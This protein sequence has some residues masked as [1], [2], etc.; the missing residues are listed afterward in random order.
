MLVKLVGESAENNAWNTCVYLVVSDCA[1]LWSIANQAPLSMGFFRQEYG[2]G[3]LSPTLRGPPDPGIKSTSPALH[4][5][6]T[7]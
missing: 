3:L 2:S 5:V 7:F 6:F 4:V 1:I